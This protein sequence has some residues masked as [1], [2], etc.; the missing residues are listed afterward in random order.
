MV[1]AKAVSPVSPHAIDVV[2]VTAT[3]R[4]VIAFANALRRESML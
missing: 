1:A 4:Q 3:R 2:M